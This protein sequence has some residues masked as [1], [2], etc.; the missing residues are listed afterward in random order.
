VLLCCGKNEFHLICRKAI[1]IIKVAGEAGSKVFRAAENIALCVDDNGFAVKDLR[2]G[3]LRAQALWSQVDS[4]VA[5]EPEA[6]N[7]ELFQG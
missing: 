2:S 3:R 6:D 7:G 5:G 1:L 4:L